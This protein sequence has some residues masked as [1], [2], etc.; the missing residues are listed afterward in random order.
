MDRLSTY[1]PATEEVFLLPGPHHGCTPAGFDAERDQEWATVGN[2]RQHGRVKVALASLIVSLIISAQRTGPEHDYEH[3][4]GTPI[5][6]VILL[7]GFPR[8]FQNIAKLIILVTAT[9]EQN[10]PDRGE[11]KFRK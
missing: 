8:V 7:V 2:T 10:A 1:S 11:H 4:E 9:G 3:P 6:A 5:G